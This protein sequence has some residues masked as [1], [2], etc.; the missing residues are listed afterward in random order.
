[1]FC[2]VLIAYGCNPT[3]SGGRDQEDLGL[4]PAKADSLRNPILKIPNTKARLAEWLS[5]RVSA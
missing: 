1:M 5:D 3:Y 4:K 2:W